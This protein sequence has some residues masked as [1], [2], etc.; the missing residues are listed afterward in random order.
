MRIQFYGDSNLAGYS[1]EHERNKRGAAYSG[2]HFTFAGIASRLLDAEY[3]N[4]SVSGATILGRHNSVMSFFDKMDFYEDEPKWQ[5]GR[6]PADVCVVNIGA[7]NVNRNGKEEIQRDYLALL[8][9]LRQAHPAAHIVV[10]NGY[11]WD[12]D[13]TANYTHEVVRKSADKRMSRVVF[14]W[15]F[16][17][18]HGC[19]YDHAGM[20]RVLAEHLTTVNPAWRAVRAMDVMDGFGREGDVANGSFE[21]AAPFGGFGWRYFQAGA[22]RV[23]APNESPSGEWFLRLP[24]NCQVHQPNPAE[25]SKRYTYR[26]K[27]RS[28]NSGEAKIRIE[29]RDQQFR[30]EIEGASRE[31][32][33]KP[34]LNWREYSVSANS[35]DGTGDKSRDAWQIIVRMI[36]NAGTV[37]CD[38]V[39]L[40]AATR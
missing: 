24:E 25:K 40:T 13:E 5:F 8:R 35:P 30:N 22:V 10:M 38:N 4:I 11:G 29:F 12:R 39:R 34:G 6:F 9:K 17:E 37:E 15:L 23:H 3:Q 28:P 26:L 32:V 36:S 7:N 19:E 31:F 20:A 1:L 14:P 27:L 33:F 2:C 18:W 21:F 16:N